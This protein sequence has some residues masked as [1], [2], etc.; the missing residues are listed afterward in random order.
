[1]SWADTPFDYVRRNAW[2]L[3]S[4]HCSTKLRNCSKGHWKM[5]EITSFWKR[6]SAI[7]H[8]LSADV[9]YEKEQYLFTSWEP[10]VYKRLNDQQIIPKRGLVSRQ[11]KCYCHASVMWLNIWDARWK[12]TRVER[13]LALLFLFLFPRLPSVRRHSIFFWQMNVFWQT[14]KK[15]RR[16]LF[17]LLSNDLMGERMMREKKTALVNNG[18]SGNLFSCN[19]KG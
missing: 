1:M 19:G 6:A 9:P 3:V 16:I 10:W 18:A 2:T 4:S 8:H 5:D 11:K 15:S 14:F 17:F 12:K 7:Y 13:S